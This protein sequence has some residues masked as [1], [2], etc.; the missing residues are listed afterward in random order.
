MIKQLQQ[1]LLAVT[2]G[3]TA[4]IALPQT[5]EIMD[6]ASENLAQVVIA[7]ACLYGATKGTRAL[8][9]Y[10]Q[11][12]VDLQQVQA[13]QKLRV[14]ASAITEQA[15]FAVEELKGRKNVEQMKQTADWMQE[16]AIY[17]ARN[18][19]PDLQPTVRR[20]MGIRKLGDPTEQAWLNSLPEFEAAA[21]PAAYV[22]PESSYV[23]IDMSELSF[24]AESP[25]QVGGSDLQIKGVRNGDLW[26]E[27]EASNR[28]IW[29]VATTQ[30]GKT[31]AEYAMLTHAFDR[32]EGKAQAIITDIKGGA[33]T[34][35]CGI[36]DYYFCDDTSA[37]PRHAANIEK[38]V[39]ALSLRR[40][41]RMKNGGT[42]SGG[43]KPAPLFLV[44][45]ELNSF[46]QKAKEWDLLNPPPSK[47]EIAAGEEARLK[48]ATQIGI[49][50]LEIITQGLED[51]VRLIVDAQTSRIEEFDFGSGVKFTGGTRNNL[52]MAGISRNGDYI[53]IRD[54]FSFN[55]RGM[56]GNPEADLMAYDREQPNKS[57]PI[58][59]T[60]MRGAAEIVQTPALDIKKMKRPWVAIG[61]KPRTTAFTSVPTPEPQSDPLSYFK[62]N[63]TPEMTD[64]EL[65]A[66]WQSAGG[67]G[68]RSPN[69][70][71]QFRELLS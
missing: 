6:R 7:G 65:W 23:D 32:S 68:N 13:K 49:H 40:A 41:A 59:A 60:N 11:G 19:E 24:V 48:L 15:N 57:I 52:S 9:W 47:Q 69:A 62:A 46:V 55:C 71:K 63:A 17:V 29:L 43:Q 38:A 20:E 4:A 12:G 45:P 22:A 39:K 44:I 25:Q 70:I 34:E 54:F 35:D 53:G 14:R 1:S 8:L 66:V 64:D 16:L 36:P 5:E 37:M 3:I 51:N 67:N 33:F 10:E 28:H 26:Q 2:V 18:I 56:A 31:W 27:L 21:L 58:A 61:G 50:I 30:S 42:W